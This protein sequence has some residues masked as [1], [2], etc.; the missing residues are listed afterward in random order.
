MSVSVPKNVFNI[1]E[2]IVAYV[3]DFRKQQ[4]INIRKL[5][6]DKNGDLSIGK[7]FNLSVDDWNDLKA[8]WE[9]LIE[10]VDQNLK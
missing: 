7:G 9:D 8:N 3:G 2:D 4:W 5:Y 10:Y 1:G 6:T